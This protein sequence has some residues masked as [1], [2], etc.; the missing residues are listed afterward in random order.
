VTQ[1]SARCTRRAFVLGT[2]A[3]AIAPRADADD[4][5]NWARLRRGGLVLLMRHGATGADL[6]DPP[7]YRLDDC[8]TQRNLSEQ[9]RAQARQMG[10]RLRREKVPIARVYTSPWCRCR[11]T[12]TLAFGRAEDWEPLSSVFDF[13]QRDAEFTERVRKR[14]AGYASR[15]PGGNV[16]M[17]THNV[18]VAALTRL[19]IA[20]AEIVVVRPDGCCG[21]RAL[22]RLGP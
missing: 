10:E 19:S 1:G 4:E 14:I 18:N 22:E 2:L 3:L 16:V 6:G 5:V 7:G 17:V 20:P 9:G 21:L 15:N 13:P 11:E 8:A 12:A